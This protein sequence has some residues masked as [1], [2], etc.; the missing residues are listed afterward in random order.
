[1][2]KIVDIPEQGKIEGVEVPLRQF[3]RRDKDCQASSVTA[4]LGIPFAQPPV[5]RLRWKRP[6][7]PPP[8]W[9]GQTSRRPSAWQRDPI[10]NLDLLQFFSKAR[11]DGPAD[12]ISEDCLYLNIWVPAASGIGA[13]ST[14]RPVLAWVYGG[15]F[16]FGATSQPG[17][18]GARLCAETGCIVVSVTYRVGVL[19]WLGS[20]QLASEEGDGSGSGNYGA[21]DVIAGLEWIRDRIASFGGDASNV[22]VF[23]ESAGS[24][25]IHYL[26][27]SPETPAGLFA[28]AILMSGTVMTV[29]PRSMP[30]AQA[31]YDALVKKVTKATGADDEA[32][33]SSSIPDAMYDLSAKEIFEM[34]SSLPQD[35]PRTEYRI[36]ESKG[37]PQRRMD[38]DL[39]TLSFE[40]QG[41]FGP[42]W[43]GVLVSNDFPRIARCGLPTTLYNG[44]KGI[45][46][47]YVADEGTMFNMGIQKPASLLKYASGHHPALHSAIKKLYGIDHVKTDQDAFTVC[48]ALS[49]DILFHAPIRSTMQ[50]LASQAEIPTY[51]YTFAHRS[52][53]QLKTSVLRSEAAVKLQQTFGSMHAGELP[54]VFGNDGTD[55]HKYAR[56]SYPGPRS[57]ISSTRDADAGFTDEEQ[58]LSLTMMRA[59]GSFAG[60]RAPWA[61]MNMEKNGDTAR[62]SIEDCVVLAMG[63]YPTLGSH[64]PSSQKAL[65]TRTANLAAS[66][67]VCEQRVGDALNWKEKVGSIEA[68]DTCGSTS[69]K[70]HFWTD[71]DMDNLFLN[72]YGD[73]RIAFQLVP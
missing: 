42:V 5:G 1:M 61:Q 56:K 20:S 53:K 14:A 60:G 35:R 11:S 34:A 66:I 3:C 40:A 51:A 24:I 27:I 21:W 31:T 52:S 12:T 58:Q 38:H 7:R 69:D 68:Y 55:G 33:T 10:Q 48:A 19:G 50:S 32:C 67:S 30:S 36:D 59:Y 72:Y 39:K 63:D 49:G 46:I 44:Q 65:E 4:Y 13:S 16:A 71:N 57:S 2:S 8:T 22:T 47:G 45:L 23:G 62:T 54:F 37:R 73:E 25:L 43:D 18:D 26:L 28:R 41:H 64:T 29:P 17:Y 6:Q 70:H 15:G 9:E